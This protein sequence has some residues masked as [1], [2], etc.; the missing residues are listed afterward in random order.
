[1]ACDNCSEPGAPNASI[2][3]NINRSRPPFAWGAMVDWPEVLMNRWHR[4]LRK[5]ELPLIESLASPE[6]GA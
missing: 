5:D 2:A 4:E 6:D 3:E 1:M